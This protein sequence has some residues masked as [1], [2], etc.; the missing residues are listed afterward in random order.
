MF[1]PES[2]NEKHVDVIDRAVADSVREL[3][4]KKFGEITEFSKT[5]LLDLSLLLT[6][7]YFRR[8]LKYY[9]ENKKHI[10][11]KYAKEIID[12]VSL[13]RLGERQKEEDSESLLKRMF[14]RGD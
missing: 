2:A 3:I 10:D 5:E 13:L 12:T 6:D 11:R 14:S 9:I 7:K 1:E 8:L 4:G